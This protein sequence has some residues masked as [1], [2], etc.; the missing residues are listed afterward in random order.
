[1]QLSIFYRNQFN[2]IELSGSHTV[3][4]LKK[5]LISG[6]ESIENLLILHSGKI[7]PDETKIIDIDLSKI[8]FFVAA[9]TEQGKSEEFEEEEDSEL[10]YNRDLLVKAIDESYGYETM[11]QNLFSSPDALIDFIEIVSQVDQ[12]AFQIFSQNV[13]ETLNFFKFSHDEMMQFLIAQSNFHNPRLQAEIDNDN[14]NGE[15]S[16]ESIEEEEYSEEEAP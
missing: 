16:T 1:M 7:L 12:R 4:D 8:D 14:E 9:S 10:N 11:R 15:D 3:I 2:A 13:L 6:E 5:S